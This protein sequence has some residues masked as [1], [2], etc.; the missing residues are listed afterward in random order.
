MPVRNRPPNSLMKGAAIT[1]VHTNKIKKTI[2]LISSFFAAAGAFSQFATG[3]NT[4]AA[5]FEQILK[6]ADRATRDFMNLPPSWSLKKYAPVPQHQGP[7]GTCVAWSAGYAART[8]S[9]AIQKNMTRADSLKKYA[10]SPGYLYYKVKPANDIACSAGA[11][12]L[13]AMQVMTQNGVMLKNEGLVDCT[14]TVPEMAELQ[15]AAPYKIKDFLSLNKTYDSITKND[16]IKIKKSL[17]EKNPVVISMKMY[18]SF[19]KVGAT[20]TWSPSSDDLLIGRHAMC[21]VGYDDKVNG[22]SFEV[23]NSWGP[24]WGN[25]GFGWLSYKQLMTYGS[26]VVELMDFEQGKATLSG[27]IT[28]TRIDEQA[29]ETIM[30]VTRAKINAGP[31]P[32]KAVQQGDFSLYKFTHAYSGGT[33]FKMKFSTS[34]RSYIYV[35]ARDSKAVISRLFPPAPSVSAAIN[36]AN[37]TYYFPSDSTHARLDG[38][39]GTENFCILYT[40]SDIDFE[41]L[42]GYI[43]ESGVTIFQGVKDKLGSRLLA[44]QHVKFRD[45][46]ISFQAPADDRSVLCFFV[47]MD[48]R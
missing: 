35:F 29:G 32:A 8:I 37:A 2:L 43:R 9:F 22:G 21:I 48:H 19:E 3:D 41:G 42:I 46:R 7:Y 28:F 33:A 26:Y 45:D 14:V 44:L 10:F 27:D 16:I 12:I 1:L 15:K 30:P 20:G 4:T 6:T 31:A 24:G 38:T 5:E 17:V 40:K 25:K 36:S 47:E 39:A 13:S 11:S 34:A 23:M 18:D